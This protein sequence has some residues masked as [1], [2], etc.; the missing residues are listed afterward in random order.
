MIKSLSMPLLPSCRKDFVP[1]SLAD[2][3]SGAAEKD[4]SNNSF[5]KFRIVERRY[6]VNAQRSDVVI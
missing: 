3:D 1:G 5:E 2:E 4:S 6:L